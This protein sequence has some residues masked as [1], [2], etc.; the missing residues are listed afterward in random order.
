MN[1][2][3]IHG[4]RQ[5]SYDK[6]ASNDRPRDVSHSIPRTGKSGDAVRGEDENTRF[7]SLVLPHLG[8]AYSLARWLT[9]NRTDAED[10]VQD[11][12]LRAFNAIASVTD[13]S[14][15]AWM[16]AIVRNAA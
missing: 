4:D 9:G 1:V 13:G 15:R 7:A 10:V 3:T 5:V 2:V 6:P 11:A 12:C 8:E 14:A 16:L